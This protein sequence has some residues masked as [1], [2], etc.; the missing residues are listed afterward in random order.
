LVRN[1]D[2]DTSYSLFGRGEQMEYATVYDDGRCRYNGVACAS[3]DAPLLALIV[4]VAPVE[5]R[6]AAPPPAIASP[7]APKQS[8]GSFCS[9]RRWRRP[10]PPRCTPILMPSLLAVLHNPTI[11]ALQSTSTQ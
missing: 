9:R 4:Q 11:A 2:G 10:W 7:L 6:S 8:A 1:A 5:V 3:D